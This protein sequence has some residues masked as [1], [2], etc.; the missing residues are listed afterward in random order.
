MGQVALG[1]CY[2]NRIAGRSSSNLA[3]AEEHYQAAL[4][5]YS[6]IEDKDALTATLVN[7][8]SLRVAQN[9]EEDV[10][11]LEARIMALLEDLDN[12]ARAI[13]ALQ[14]I[15]VAYSNMLGRDPVRYAEA[16][17]SALQRS[18]ELAEE[19]EPFSLPA[20]IDNMVSVDL[21]LIQLGQKVDIDQLLA[22]LETIAQ[23]H[24]AQDAP[25]IWVTTCRHQIQL[26]MAKN[27]WAE[28]IELGERA[29]AE[30]QSLLSEGESLD[31]RRHLI[32]DFG[33]LSDMA[34]VARA[35][36]QGP[37]AALKDWQRYHGLLFGKQRDFEPLLLDE[38]ELY[39]LNAEI[40]GGDILIMRRHT[41][42]TLVRLDGLNRDFWKTMLWDETNG[43]VALQRQVTPKARQA[44]QKRLD[45]LIDQ[46]STS[47]ADMLAFLEGEGCCHLYVEPS[48]S[49][50]HCPFAALR[51]PDGRVLGE[52]MTVSLSSKCSVE[53]QQSPRQP[54]RTCIAVLDQDLK[55]SKIERAMLEEHFDLFE[56]LTTLSETQSALRLGIAA[57]IWHFASHGRHDFEWMDAGGLRCPDGQTLT[58]R[59]IYEY[60]KLQGVPLVMLAACESGLSDA[61]RLPSEQFGLPGA[62]HYAGASIVIS[63]LWPVD[64]LASRLFAGAFYEA[65]MCGEAPEIALQIAQR[66]LRSLPWE[67]VPYE[68]RQALSLR[69]GDDSEDEWNDGDDLPF[70]HPSHWAG[71]VLTG[72]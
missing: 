48:G 47:F 13:T 7:L 33:D 23:A 68:N 39:C 15:G 65:W 55:G 3:K 6:S 24:D 51:L 37:E 1:L 18:Y 70:S 59:W 4:D 67:D 9:R 54:Q 49:W 63:T 16:A 20:I 34:I 30:F 17:R 38:A 62:F 72:R 10:V 25:E 8:V 64:N 45:E 22:R 60:A 2:R 61:T 69:L 57:D 31:L 35:A 28:A 11:P 5:F 12:P 19:F 14:N 36:E 52:Q 21:E 50:H 43:L 71:F 66:Y 58:A 42:F 46:I 40:D 41:G 26:Y 32:G 44:A 53:P 27:Q 29:F 56:P